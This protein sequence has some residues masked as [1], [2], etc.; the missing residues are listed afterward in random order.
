MRYEERFERQI[1][2]YLVTYRYNGRVQHTQMA[3][4]P[5]TRMRVRVSVDPMDG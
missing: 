1:D 4:D 2:G 3:Y 5:G